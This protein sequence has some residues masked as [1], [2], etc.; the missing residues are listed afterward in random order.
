MQV[1]A[2]LVRPAPGKGDGVIRVNGFLRG[3]ALPEADD[4]AVHEIDGWKN[5]H[6]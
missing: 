2:S 5:K 4:L 6:V 1:I 3:F